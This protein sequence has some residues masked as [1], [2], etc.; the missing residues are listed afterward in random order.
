MSAITKLGTQVRL[1]DGRE[2]TV[3]FNVGRGLP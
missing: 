3:V 1:P 2:G